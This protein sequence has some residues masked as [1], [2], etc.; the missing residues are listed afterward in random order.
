MVKEKQFLLP[1]NSLSHYLK[2]FGQSVWKIPLEGNF[3]C[4]N[5]D[6]TKGTGG[7]TFCSSDGSSS[8]FQTKLLIKEQIEYGIAHRS[9]RRNA[10]KFIAYFQSYTNTYKPVHEL[11]ELYDIILGYPE[12]V[13]LSIGTR[14][15]CLP[16]DVLRLLES[17]TKSI[18]VWVDL[19][20]QSINDKTLKLVNRGHSSFDFFECLTLIKELA[21]SVKICVHLMAGLPSESLEETIKSVEAVAKPEIHGIKLHNLCVLKNTAIAKDYLSGELKALEMDE[22]IDFVIKALSILPP[23][24]IIHRLMAEPSRASELLAPAWVLDKNKFLSELRKKMYERGIRQGCE[25]RS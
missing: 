15:D 3:T 17:Y 4:P 21:P 19:G 23:Q 12:I 8:K 5:R 25:F 16:N 7:C 20:V 22:Y 1:Y 24:M 11:K 9:S 14:P 13:C 18:E 2:K 10:D 6:G